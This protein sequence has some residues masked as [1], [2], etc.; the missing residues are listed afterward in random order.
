MK[1]RIVKKN[2]DSTKNFLSKQVSESKFWQQIALKP[3]FDLLSAKS[4]QD[5]TQADKNLQFQYNSLL[6][7]LDILVKYF[8]KGY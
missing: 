7:H 8:L 3:A 1:K 2:S 6:F 4:S 5:F